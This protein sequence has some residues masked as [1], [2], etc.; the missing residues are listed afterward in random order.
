MILFLNNGIKVIVIFG[1][2][3]EK[4]FCNMAEGLY[5]Y[6]EISDLKDMLQKSGDLYGDNIAYKIKRNGEYITISHKEIRKMINGLGTSLINM[7]LKGK[8]IAVIGENR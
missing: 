3:F 2:E 4:G 1:E 7:G 8:R 6:I 5:E